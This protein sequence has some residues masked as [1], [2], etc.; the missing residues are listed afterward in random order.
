M[1][2]LSAILR[3]APVRGS[4]FSRAE[5]AAPWGVETHGSSAAIFHVVL[6]GSGWLRVD[7]G[8][9][10]SFRAGDLLL[11]AHGHPHVLSDAPDGAATWI[12]KLPT[13]HEHGLPCV[14]VEGPGAHTS[15]LC[16]SFRFSEEA[17][18]L[19]R[20]Q[21]PPVLLVQG[22]AGA[23]A[24]WLDQTLRL[25]ADEVDGRRPGSELLLARLADI[26]FVQILR[27]WLEQQPQ[28]GGWL[29]AL[30]DPALGR[31]L[32]LMHRRPGSP[33]TAEDLAKKAGLSRTAFYERFQTAVGQS[34]A[35]YLATWRMT[36]AR[37]TLRETSLPMIEVA[38]RV[39]YGS[40][41]A[42]S[43]AFKRVVGQ[44]PSAW[45]RAQKVAAK[46]SPSTSS[47]SASASM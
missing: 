46:P 1:D 18:Q 16:G 45:R 39:G 42:F 37:K 11:M 27:S 28:A 3:H 19:V 23:T 41:A 21:L 34:P 24:A 20:P 47:S 10:R 14:R 29:G 40:E 30:S 13:T 7:G 5:L 44:S 33:W 22:G 6:H 35:S 31:A 36:L 38:G 2:A 25:M 26:L 43:R 9:P 15:I 17:H 8:P 32:D 4:L 12:Q